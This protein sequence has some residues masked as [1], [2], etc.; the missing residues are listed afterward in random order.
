MIMLAIEHRTGVGGFVIRLA[1]GTIHKDENR[2]DGW[3]YPVIHTYST[4]ADADEAAA[5]ICPECGSD[6]I[7]R[8]QGGVF[9]CC[10]CGHDFDDAGQEVYVPE[11]CRWLAE[12]E[13][14]WES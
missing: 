11:S 12:T 14:S 9:E 10:D 1:D 8:V 6:D 2:A 3:G 13:G 4:M 5:M 7:E